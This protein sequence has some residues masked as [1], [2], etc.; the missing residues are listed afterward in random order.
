MAHCISMAAA[1]VARISGGYAA[2]SVPCKAMI[3]RRLL[4]DSVMVC[5]FD[6]AG[7]ALNALLGFLDVENKLAVSLFRRD[8]CMTGLPGPG[9]HIAG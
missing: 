6:Q 3:A 5:V 1:A 4:V 9:F 2:S 7:D 8:E